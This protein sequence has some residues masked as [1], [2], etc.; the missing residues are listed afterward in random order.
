M[1]EIASFFAVN[2]IAAAAREGLD[3]AELCRSVGLDPAA[4]PSTPMMST[5]RFYGLWER[6]MRGVER[7]DGFPMRYART[8]EVD[9]YGPL[10]MAMR[11]AGGPREALAI[12]R[13]FLVALTSSGW[14]ELKEAETHLELSFH[15]PGPRRLGMRAANEAT[16]A[17]IVCLYRELGGR[18]GPPRRVRF[19]HPAPADLS[20]H[21]AL[22]GVEPEFDA[23]L[24]ALELDLALV[25]VENPRA[26]P[27]M[28]AFLVAHL[29]AN[30]PSGDSLLVR[31]L[32][33]ELG[34]RLADSPGVDL[35]ARQLG[36]SG[37]T[38]QRRLEEQGLSFRGVLDE[39]R[40]EAALKLLRETDTPLLEVAFLLGFANQ[41]AMT[42]AVKRWTGQTPGRVRTGR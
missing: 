31:R 12:S 19:R 7:A 4:P 39:L 14:F 22:F 10:G 38:L 20:E 9:D 13:Q 23:P 34:P 28:S 35:V 2:V 8:V 36:M 27:T 5:E 33:R 30:T 11:T 32:R 15:R 41:Q 29:E 17:E 25:D 1:R 6:I 21:R 18:D 37:R 40:H 24:D 42:R 3:R 26:D 16:L